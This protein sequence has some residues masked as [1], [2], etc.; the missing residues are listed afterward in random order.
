MQGR[1]GNDVVNSAQTTSGEAIDVGETVSD[2]RSDGLASPCWPDEQRCYVF[3][4]LGCLISIW[5]ELPVLLVSYSASLTG[6]EGALLPKEPSRQPYAS[7]P[8]T[9][10]RNAGRGEPPPQRAQLPS[11]RG[12][13]GSPP[14]RI[15]SPAAHTS[16]ARISRRAAAP[17][18]SAP[19]SKDEERPRMGPHQRAGGRRLASAGGKANKDLF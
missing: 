1:R 18:H 12:A 16:L 13:E 8:T 11:A 15:G 7:R 5:L 4:Q 14:A 6:L 2:G 19:S 17:R 9:P 10:E 3:T